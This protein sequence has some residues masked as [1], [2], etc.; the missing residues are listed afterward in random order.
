MALLGQ[1]GSIPLCD[2]FAE[3]YPDAELVLMGVEEPLAL[4]HAQ[5]ECGPR[6][7][8]ALGDS[9]SAVR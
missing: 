8:R 1:G 6:R 2:V 5:R 9:T 4:V 3:T 7:D